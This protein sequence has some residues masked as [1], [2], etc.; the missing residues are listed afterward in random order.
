MHKYHLEINE[1]IR[2][3]LG[4]VFDTLSDHNAMAEWMNT[5]IRRIRD[6]TASAEG[7][8]GTGSVRTLRLMGFLEFDE[9]V[10]RSVKP[11]LIEYRITRGSP[12]KD[13][14]G[15]IQ[16]AEKNGGVQITWDIRFN[17]DLPLAG[18]P[19]AFALKTAISRGLKKLRQNLEAQDL[20]RAMVG[21]P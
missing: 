5:D 14:I 20:P 9:T 11:K 19:V 18:Y 10:T 1:L 8:N 21:N 17:M 13:H 4:Q 7:V 15:L 3:P 12:L 2:A 16:L 6:A